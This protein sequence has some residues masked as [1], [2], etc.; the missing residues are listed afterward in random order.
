MKRENKTYP[1]SL[2]SSHWNKIGRVH[3]IDLL[4]KST[5]G[6][7]SYIFEMD[8]LELMEFLEGISMNSLMDACLKT[9]PTP[10]KAGNVESA[11]TRKAKR[12]YRAA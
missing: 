7:P 10:R 11:Q 3:F 4:F 8:P 5:G 12:A 2:G 9:I 1:D 6:L